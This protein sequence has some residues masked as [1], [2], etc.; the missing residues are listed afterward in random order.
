MSDAE[1]VGQGGARN[2]TGLTGTS[3]THISEGNGNTLACISQIPVLERQDGNIPGDG[4]Q[5]EGFVAAHFPSAKP[6]CL[7]ILQTPDKLMGE[8][9]F[10]VPLNGLPVRR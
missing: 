1:R 4:S 3:P 9:S 6:Q 10:G 5:L 2:K 7:P 8:S